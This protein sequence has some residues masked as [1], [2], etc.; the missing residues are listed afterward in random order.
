MLYPS[1]L[2]RE[3]RVEWLSITLHKRVVYSS[4]FPSNG[5]MLNL[6]HN[7]VWGRH[8]SVCLIQ[9]RSSVRMFFQLGSNLQKIEC[10]KGTFSVLL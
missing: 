5:N 7:A 9:K 4:F 6:Q 2:L 1:N 8:A 10:D 3:E